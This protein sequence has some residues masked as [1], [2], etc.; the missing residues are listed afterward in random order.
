M[1][2]SNNN[3]KIFLIAQSKIS[4]KHVIYILIK[5][6]VPTQSINMPKIMMLNLFFKDI[7]KNL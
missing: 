5:Q 3:V 6:F 7:R 2:K 4:K 1:N